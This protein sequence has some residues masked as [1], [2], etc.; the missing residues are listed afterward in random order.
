MKKMPQP[1]VR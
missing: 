1:V